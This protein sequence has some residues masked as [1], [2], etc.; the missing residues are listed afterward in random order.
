MVDALPGA[1]DVSHLKKDL[2]LTVPVLQ[3]IENNLL[4]SEQSRTKRQKI[5]R[6]DLE[7]LALLPV[8]AAVAMPEVSFAMA[9][10]AVV[11]FAYGVMLWRLGGWTAYYWRWG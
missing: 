4:R 9:K 3:H 1:R 10:Y 8:Y 6:F 5:T 7:N 11:G 2:P